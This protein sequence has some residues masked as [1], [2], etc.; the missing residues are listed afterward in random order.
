MNEE[1]ALRN[2]RLYKWYLAFREPMLWGPIIISCIIN[3]G[4]MSLP[5]IYFM[6]SVVLLWSIALQIPFGA[7]ADL[8]GRKKTLMLGSILYLVGVILFSRIN[9]PLDV[10]V[11]NFVWETA[12]PLICGAD[13]AFLYDTLKAVG[14]E[15]EYKKI[16]GEATSNQLMIVAICSLFTGFLGEYSLRLPLFLSIPGVLVSLFACFLL[17]EPPTMKTYTPGEQ[18]SIMKLGVLFVA[19]HKKVKWIIGF[20][21]LIS[22]SSKIWFFS[23]NPYFELVMLDLRYYGILFFFCNMIAWFFSRYAHRSAEIVNERNTMALII[24]LMA[25]PIIFMGSFVS[26]ACVV[27]IFPQ[28]VVRGFMRPFFGEFMNRYLSSENRATVL[29]V[30]SAVAELAQ[31]LALMCFSFVLVSV[32]LPLCLVG[33]GCLV[34]SFGIFAMVKYRRI[35]EP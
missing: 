20:M 24:L 3:L 9:S 29:S 22:V 6:E 19:N 13:S 16:D 4:H 1:D 21:T 27:L 7:L 35:F 12:I 18:V 33:L 8:I 15:S 28:N 31:F 5:E 32:G 2:I 34:L 14:K 23:Y 11:A 26:V 10:W 30:Q 25:A 17:K